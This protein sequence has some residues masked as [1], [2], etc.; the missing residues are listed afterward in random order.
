MSLQKF[1]I[2]S[3]FSNPKSSWTKFFWLSFFRTQIFS[4]FSNSPTPLKLIP[5]RGGEET[6]TLSISLVVVG[7]KNLTLKL[8]LLFL[9]VCC[10]CCSLCCCWSRNVDL[11][12]GQNPVSNSWDIAVV[13]V[14]AENELLL[15]LLYL[16]LETYIFSFGQNRVS[17]SWD[18]D[19]VGFLWCWVSGGLQSFSFQVRLSWGCDNISMAY[20][21]Y[22]SGIHVAYIL[23]SLRHTSGISSV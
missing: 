3:L 7:P 19:D 21:R 8:L 4:T 20:L 9:F 18:I 12:L 17:N 22:L 2:T 5:F 1:C 10:C 11:K 6:K 13:I 23:A 16:I 14:V 15:L